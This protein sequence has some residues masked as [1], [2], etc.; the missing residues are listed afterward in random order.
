MAWLPGKVCVAIT[1]NAG[2][3]FI[4]RMK[5]IANECVRSRT[6]QGTY[7]SL[8][9]QVQCFS[10]SI[11]AIRWG[12]RR[13]AVKSS[14]SAVMKTG[15][16]APLKTGSYYV[17]EVVARKPP[18]PRSGRLHNKIIK[19]VNLCSYCAGDHFI[20][21]R[22]PSTHRRLSLPRCRCDGLRRISCE[23]NMPHRWT[24]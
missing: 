9:L 23:H 8:Y 14:V 16:A 11:H 12:Y 4:P 2:T 13:V 22:L 21:I 1:K 6:Y 3:Y 18:R 10:K 7:R 19:F 24:K 17:E 20:Q 5:M 15:N